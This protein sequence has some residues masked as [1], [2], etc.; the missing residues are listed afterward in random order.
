MVN[1]ISINDLQISPTEFVH[2][3]ALNPTAMM[4][5]LGA[6]TSRSAGMPT[7]TDIIWDLKHKHYCLHENIE[8]DSQDI[9]NHSVRNRI[10]HYMDSKG[11]P[12]LWSEEEYSFYFE[13]LFKDDYQKQQIYLNNV[14]APEKISLNT[15]HRILAGMMGSG[16]ANIVFTTNFDEVIETAY[17]SVF[18]L[19]LHSFHLEGSYAALEALNANRFPIYTKLHGDFRYQKIKNLSDDLQE[20]DAALMRCLLAAATRYGMVV[21]GYSGRDANIMEMLHNAIQQNNAFPGGLF[22]T[23]F[24]LESVT[25]PVMQLI[26]EARS[27]K[28]T[29]GIVETGTYDETMNRIWRQIPNKKAEVVK[30]INPKTVTAVNIPLPNPGSEFPIVRTNALPIVSM[31]ERCGSAKHRNSVGY[32]DIKEVITEKNPDALLTNLDGIAFFGNGSEITKSFGNENITSIAPSPLPYSVAQI[33]ESTHLKSFY[34]KTLVKALC[35][36]K[37]LF[38]SRKGATFFIYPDFKKVRETLFDPLKNV[39]GYNGNQGYINGRVPELPDTFWIEALSVR[40]DITNNNAWL[41]LKPD[42]WISPQAKRQDAIEFLRGKKLKRWNSKQYDLLDAWI[43]I[44]FG[45]VRKADV[46]VCA[47]PESDYPAAFR[48]CTRT[49]FSRHAGGRHV[50]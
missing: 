21:S 37:P 5:L 18:G 39:L 43:K 28:I 7:A 36:G 42:I 44:I 33:D 25:P 48:I 26:S 17:A 16:L 13:L 14:L 20:N 2:Q 41:L 35:E 29:A 24:N 27:R 31:P 10:Q 9:G 23:A 15:G 1:P 50:R 3:Y 38:S 46:V 34:E 6:G 49:A 45:G 11:Y 32:D 8:I 4:W 30:Q 22:W 40:V 12:A 47:Y 19:N